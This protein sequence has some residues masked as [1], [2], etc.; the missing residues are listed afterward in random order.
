MNEATAERHVIFGSGQVGP[1]LASHL[2]QQGRKVRIV[3]RSA[4]VTP[5]GCEVLIGDATDAAFCVRAVEGATVVYHCMNPAYEFQAWN[6]LLPCFMDNLV[7]ACARARARLVVLDNLYMLGKP[8]GR[9]LDENTA[10]NPCS[11]KGEVRA[12]V[13]QSLFAAHKKG[14][15]QAVVG[16]ASDFYGPGG[17]LTHV[18][19]QF[20]P[21]ALRGKVAR[22]LVDPD[23]VHTYHFIP[24]VAHGL[25]TLGNAELGDMGI[26]WMLP[27]A[28]AQTLRHL[29]GRFAAE[30]GREIRISQAPGW[31]L[32]SLGLFMG[33]V[34]ELNEM[35]YQWEEPFIV[36][37]ERFRRRFDWQPIEAA[38]AS[39]QTVN[40]A[41][42][43][44]EM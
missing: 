32:Q 6:D 27:C 4:G 3:K 31:M 30:L 26:A 28:P 41:R 12:R 15:V 35:S 7:A 18:G 23:A 9:A 38:D 29:I 16:R 8:N 43:Q 33:I 1:H 14:D 42:Q 10:M 22:L 11:R 25:A 24:D 37:D 13:A 21:A 19:D 40:W 17:R 34:R 2:V 5:L 20:W 44:Y 39:H 36:R